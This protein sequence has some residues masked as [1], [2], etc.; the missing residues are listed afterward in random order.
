MP[1]ERAGTVNT[2]DVVSEKTAAPDAWI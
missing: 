1:V 2:G